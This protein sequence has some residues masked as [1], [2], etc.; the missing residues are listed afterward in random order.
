MDLTKICLSSGGSRC[1]STRCCCDDVWSRAPKL[2]STSS[3]DRRLMT[4]RCAEPL[5]LG[6]HQLV[7]I[8]NG[9]RVKTMTMYPRCVWILRMSSMKHVGYDRDSAISKKCRKF[10]DPLGCL[11]VC[12]WAQHSRRYQFVPSF[13]EKGNIYEH[14]VSKPTSDGIMCRRLRARKPS[15]TSAKLS[16]A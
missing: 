8:S 10:L 15:L 2:P 5:E 6:G 1:T 4:P 7:G 14:D 11:Q 12:R 13:S 9:Y 16:S 3:P